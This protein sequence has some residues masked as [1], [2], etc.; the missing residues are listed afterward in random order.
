[1]VDSPGDGAGASKGGKSSTVSPRG[2]GGAT[3]SGGLPGARGSKTDKADG[4]TS[5]KYKEAD[6]PWW[7]YNTAYF[8]L[9]FSEN[10]N[11][12]VDAVASKS[13]Q[14]KK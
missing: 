13:K 2:V 7:D 6:R 9:E 10:F 11:E 14:G 1:M 3:A 12:A 8:K 4:A 5:S